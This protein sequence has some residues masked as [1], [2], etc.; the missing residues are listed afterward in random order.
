MATIEFIT[1]ED[2]KQFRTD[3]LQDLK[4]A[5]RKP[6]LL[7]SNKEWLKSYEVREILKISPSTLQTLRVNGTIP[8]SKIGR[9]M[10]L[11]VHQ[12]LLSEFTKAVPHHQELMYKTSLLIYEEFFKAPEVDACSYPSIKT[13]PKLG[14]N[15]V[16]DQASAKE[17]PQILRGN[18]RPR[19]E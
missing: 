10:L 9:L 8:Y 16:F 6:K 3:L 17:E 5:L 15:I 4:E 1:K 2:L 19:D 13:L 18:G 12:F 7:E 14:Y 11:M